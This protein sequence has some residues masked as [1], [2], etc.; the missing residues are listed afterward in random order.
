MQSEY[1]YNLVLTRRPYLETEHFDFSKVI[2]WQ[3]RF[4][5]VCVYFRYNIQHL[6]DKPTIFLGLIFITKINT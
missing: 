1:L 4:I 3:T 5:Y 2:G 6:H